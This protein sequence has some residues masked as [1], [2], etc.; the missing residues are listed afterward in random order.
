MNSSI[1]IVLFLAISALGY[2]V[3]NDSRP[4][5]KWP[6]KY[7]F[8]ASK[9]SLTAGWNED[10]K[11][12]RTNNRSRVDYN[13]GAVKSFTISSKKRIKKLKFG[14]RYQIHPITT[15]E[16]ENK[17]ICGKI[18][19]TVF[20]RITLETVLPKSLE[21][22]EFIGFDTLREGNY[23]KFYY[24]EIDDTTDSRKTLIAKYDEDIKVWIPIRF[25]VIE[26]NTWQENLNTHV[27]W[28]YHNFKTDFDEDVFD[29]T[30]YGCDA[31]AV[32][33]T[34][35]DE[36]ITKDLLFMDSENNQHVDHCF[37]TFK[38]KYDREYV[39][40]QE[41][42]MRRSI[43]QENMRL[44][45]T[46]NRQ[47]LGYKLSVNKFADRT[48]AEMERHRGLIR[49]SKNDVG[50]DPFPYTKT[51]V[52][53][54]ADILPKNFDL[55]IEGLITP[56]HDQEDCGSCWTFGTT[57][58]VEGAL[59]RSN[60]G[61]LLRLSN[62]ALIDCAWGFGAAGCDGGS[63]TAAYK[64]MMKYGMPTEEEYGTYQ[65]KDGFCRIDNMTDIYQIRGFTDVTPFS[66]EALKVAL[67]N[68]G[69]LSVSIDATKSLKLYS[70]G[71]FYDET[72]DPTDLNHEVTLVGYGEKDGETYWI[73]KN[74]WGTNWGI[75]GY[76][77]I[78]V[79]DNNCGIA[80]EPSYPVF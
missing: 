1:I 14:V 44:I 23:S 9:M 10:I 39:D 74:S 56:V 7:A 11:V 36:N 30:K 5:L 49:R 20:H 16:E 79:R 2:V 62:Q 57:S 15:E 31:N 63:D 6:K 77:H 51:Q 42:A 59:A 43:F 68:H 69:P 73:V 38:R 58:A 35:E 40:D 46:R 48:P 70:G 21:D 19:G 25:E 50:T 67:V 47:N 18:F 75:D 41:H 53:E 52:K 66:V 4:E 12:W 27:I 72:C 71:I 78:T 60:G 33:H 76:F 34:M 64:W 3:K 22:F 29:T 24:Q 8:E 37:E 28:D 61:R 17:M 55:R 54:I 32:T 26:Y 80:T 13:D 45:I 65:N